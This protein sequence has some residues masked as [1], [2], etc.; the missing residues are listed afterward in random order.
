MHLK[1]RKTPDRDYFGMD[2]EDYLHVIYLLTAKDT[3]ARISAIAAALKVRKPSVSQ[4]AE[5]LKK[6]G[7]ITYK[8][9]QELTLT[10]KGRRVALAIHNRHE[11]LV[12]F[13]TAIGVPKKVQEHDIHGLEHYLSPIT[14]KKLQELTKKLRAAKH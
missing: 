10:P 3:E 12:D 4:M 7:Y 5:R 11:A 6:Q 2:Q 1:Q 13:F 8:P 9:Y 14:L